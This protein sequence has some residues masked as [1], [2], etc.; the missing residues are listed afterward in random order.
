MSRE[1][2]A[3]LLEDGLTPT[4]IAREFGVAKPTICFHMRK[5]GIP[6]REE[7]AR[8]YDRDVIRAHYE[9]GHSMTECRRRFGFTEHA[10]ADAVEPGAII[11]R[12]RLE[13]IEQVLAV[14]P[15][16]NRFHLKSRL[17][18]EGLKQPQCELCGLAEWHGRVLPLELHHVNGDGRDNQ[19]ENLQLLCPNC[20]S[21]TDTWGGLNKGRRAA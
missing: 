8:R 11:R 6:A 4:E 5:L 1:A 18:R 13:P 10:W 3:R 7:S 16:R 2:V 17:L 19:L 9:A 14:G 21:Q 15:R 12:P 20:H